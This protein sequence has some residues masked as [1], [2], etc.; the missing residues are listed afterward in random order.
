MKLGEAKG[1]HNNHL[2][3]RYNYHT[4]TVKNV[5]KHVSN[6]EVTGFKDAANVRSNVMT[7]LSDKGLSKGYSIKSNDFPLFYNTNKFIVVI[8]WTDKNNGKKHRDKFVFTE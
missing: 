7:R 5:G 8:F 2:Y 3:N 6:V 1:D 4:L